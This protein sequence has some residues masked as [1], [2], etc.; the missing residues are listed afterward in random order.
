M[1]TTPDR[2]GEAIAALERGEQ[3]DWKR[4]AD[5]QALDLARAGQQHA[6][7]AAQREGAHLDALEATLGG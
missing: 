6:E 7:E 4:L 1:V 5:L 2:I 3:V